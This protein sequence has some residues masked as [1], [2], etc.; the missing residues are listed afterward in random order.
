MT[1]PAAYCT[2]T[3]LS[4]LNTIHQMVTAWPAS[5][6]VVDSEKEM[7]LS[8]RV[9][10]EVPTTAPAKV[11]TGLVV[12]VA[13]PARLTTTTESR[14][15]RTRATRIRRF[16]MLSPLNL[17]LRTERLDAQRIGRVTQTGMTR[18]SFGLGAAVC[19]AFD[20]SG[21]SASTD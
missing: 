15:T 2:D 21:G 9:S 17:D 20:E 1:W 10:V 16:M 18:R 11:V 5:S 12:L 14:P 4:G 6:P 8:V 7:P 19:R 13:A 3:E